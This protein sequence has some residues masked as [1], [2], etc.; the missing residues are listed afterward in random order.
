MPGDEWGYILT[1]QQINANALFIKSNPE[2]SKSRM[3]FRMGRPVIENSVRSLIEQCR[4]ECGAS[5]IIVAG[6]SMGGFAALY[7]GLKYGWDIISGSPPY[8]LCRAESI[9]YATGDS[10][11][12]HAEW[13]M[14]QFSD[15]IRKA[16]A[17]GYDKRCFIMWGSGEDNW[18][19]KIKAPRLLAELDAAQIKYEVKLFPFSVHSTVHSVFPTVLKTMLHV[20]LGLADS[21]ADDFDQKIL[22]PESAL[23]E[24]ISQSMKKLRIHHLKEE[25][26]CEAFLDIKDCQPSGGDVDNETARR[27]L[28][29]L[30]TGWYWGKNFKEPLPVSFSQDF[31]KLKWQKSYRRYGPVSFWFQSQ[32]LGCYEN[33]GGEDIFSWLL[34]NAGQYLTQESK[35]FNTKIKSNWRGALTRLYFFIN[36]HRKAFERQISV[37]WFP[38]IKHE[39]LMDMQYFMSQFYSEYSDIY[40]RTLGM[41]HAAAYLKNDAGLHDKIYTAALEILIVATDYYFDR[42]G[43]C[44]YGQ[45]RMQARLSALLDINIKFITSNNFSENPLLKKL[46]RKYEAIIECSSHIRR[47][48]GKLA[49]LGDI[50]DSS[51]RELDWLLRNPSNFIVAA[52]NIAFLEDEKSLSY[53]TVNGTSNIHS[54]RR[55]CDLLS[56]TWYYD[57]RQIFCDTGGG[58]S[59]CDEFAASAVAHNAFICAGMDYAT[60]DY[61]DW[62]AMD[63]CVEQETYVVVSMSHR[64]IDNVEMYRKLIWI[65]PNIIVLIDEARSETDHR[66]EQNFILNKF[67]LSKKDQNKVSVHVA[68]SFDVIIRQFARRRAI[69]LNVYKGNISGEEASLRGSRIHKGK[70]FERG[71][72]L[73]YAQEGN[74]ARFATVIECHSPEREGK[75]SEFS[76]QALKIKDDHAVITLDDGSVITEK[77]SLENLNSHHDQQMLPSGSHMGQPDKRERGR[78]FGEADWPS[79]RGS[80]IKRLLSY[81][82]H[83]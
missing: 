61:S 16:G 83:S 29:A 27:N 66:F 42:K 74:M 77:C 57:G 5:R 22:S 49:Q 56:F 71:L 76:V 10:D 38:L 80:L 70:S 50:F 19:S 35:T 6:S 36:L 81:L 54:T 34:D 41:L 9:R 28:N 14:E 53:I 78:R 26:V 4:I 15:V 69:E 12:E 67:R 59:P 17:N 46:F 39:L 30:I 31:W 55:H 82:V 43:V 45:I 21:M 58:K 52:S 72:N 44:I 32:L 40:A 7:Y 75:P 8:T 51:S 62:T 47:P 33:E 11:P 20:Y 64:L 1:V 63:S 60:P 65:K 68:S 37:D 2:Y 48:D 3:T 18:K 25:D 73:A 13:L 23:L 24:S 79:A